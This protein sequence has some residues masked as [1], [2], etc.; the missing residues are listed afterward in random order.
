M[1]KGRRTQVG[2]DCLQPHWRVPMVSLYLFLFFP[3]SKFL[4]MIG[5]NRGWGSFCWSGAFHGSVNT[6]KLMFVGVSISCFSLYRSSC[7]PSQIPWK[8]GRCLL[9][10]HTRYNNYNFIKQIIICGL[11]ISGKAPSLKK[12]FKQ[13]LARNPNWTE[14]DLFPS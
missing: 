2:P 12:K 1:S 14:P 8:C 10:V 9:Q 6:D 3:F 7:I 13:Y 5:C 4:L 11:C